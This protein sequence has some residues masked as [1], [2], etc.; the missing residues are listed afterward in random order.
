M[1]QL[2]PQMRILLAVQPAD[3]RKGIDGLVRITKEKIKED[4]FSGI[5]F[6]FKNRRGTAL[7][8]LVYD[9]QGFWLLLKRLSKGSFKWWPKRGGDVSCQLD[10]RE[11]QLLLWNG[12]PEEIKTAP[13][14]KPVIPIA[15]KPKGLRSLSNRVNLSHGSNEV[16]R[17]RDN[18]G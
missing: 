10:A 15:E 3:F 1:M 4:P 13:M 12:N 11:F 18:S 5:V 8:I 6:V 7:K 14:W 16:S 17:E 2:A 9:G